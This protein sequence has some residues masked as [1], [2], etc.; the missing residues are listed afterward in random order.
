[1]NRPDNPDIWQEASR[2]GWIGSRVARLTAPSQTQKRYCLPS[3]Q[4]HLSGL[5]PRDL[6][7]GARRQLPLQTPV[8]SPGNL[9]DIQAFAARSR[10][11]WL[12]HCIPIIPGL[13]SRPVD[14]LLGHDALP[15]PHSALSGLQV[16]MAEMVGRR[17]LNGF[18]Q[19]DRRGVRFFSTS[20]NEGLEVIH[21]LPDRPGEIDHGSPRHLTRVALIAN[22]AA[23]H[24]PVILLDPSLVVLALALE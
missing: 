20:L 14:R 3:S 1:M 4:A 11:F 15:L 19:G 2:I 17:T 10:M 9:A 7:Q 21:V 24:Q 22:G 23:D 12:C 18:Q 5:E 16:G 8:A 6:S 13:I